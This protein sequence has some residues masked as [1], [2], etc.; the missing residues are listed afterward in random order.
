MLVYADP[1][2][3][4]TTRRAHGKLYRQDMP[5]AEEHA[6]LLDALRAHPGP[7]VL[8]GYPSPLYDQALGGWQ[9][10]SCEALAEHGAAREEVLW[11]SPRAW[12]GLSR[13]QLSLEGVG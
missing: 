11:L 6:A 7:V 9:R 1:P 8:S 2:Y 10:V 13:R 4:G 5:G 12:Q 3:L